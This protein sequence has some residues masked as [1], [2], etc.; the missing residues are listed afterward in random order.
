MVLNKRI[1]GSL[2]NNRSFYIVSAVLTIIAAAFMISALSTGDTLIN[3]IDDFY[4]EYAVED[5]EFSVYNDFGEEDIASMENEFD[6]SI[7]LNRYKD[8]EYNDAKIRVFAATSKVNKYEVTKGDDVSGKNDVLLTQKFSEESDISV[9]D[10]ISFGGTEH[11][12]TG[13]AI[14]SD[15]VYML[16]KLSDTYKNDKE[17]GLA[18]VTDEAFSELEGDEV[19]YYGVR[20][21]KDNENEFR[22]TLNTDYVISSY[23]KKSSNKRISL[24]ES[25]GKSVS[26]MAATLCPVLFAIVAMIVALSLGRMVKRESNILGTFMA[27]GYKKSYLIAFYAKLAVI[28]AIAG[29]IIGI[30]LGALLIKPF[31]VFYIETDFEPFSYS[32]SY[33]VSAIIIAL[34]VPALL[35]AATAAVTA[36]VM[37]KKPAIELI[38]N[39]HKD[40]RNIKVMVKSE[41]RVPFKMQVRSLISHPLRSLVTIV[42]VMVATAVLTIGANSYDA[43]DYMLKKGAEDST[44][45]DYQYVLNYLGTEKPDSGEGVL[46]NTYEVEDADIDL[47]IA[48]ISEDSEYFGSETVDGDKLDLDKYYLTYAASKTFGAEKGEKL[49]FYD[50]NTLKEREVEIAGIIDDDM[51]AYMYTGYKNAADIMGVDEGTYNIIVSDKELDIPNDKV[52]QVITKESVKDQLESIMSMLM[53]GIYAIALVG[54]ILSILILYLVMNM[55]IT[56]SRSTISLLKILGFDQKS[57]SRMTI[58]S[59]AIL[60]VIGFVAGIPLGRFYSAASFRDSMGTYGM[61]FSVHSSALTLILEVLIIFAAYFISLR[62]LRKKAYGVDMVEALKDFRKE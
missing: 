61:T 32:N 17:F 44:A 55:T 41:A 43:V 49:S 3:A 15:Y 16:E 56:E 26:D 1:K 4:D 34:V 29:S 31:A 45:F 23:M 57:V 20:Y 36:Y 60:T 37:L 28:P 59:N 14:K 47:T 5:A 19:S 51:N 8:I 62:R 2:K 33:S 50:V 7:E 10:S 42:G 38:N 58:D 13:Y 53:V 54:F 52:S 21:N 11:T 25:Q 18:I 35:Y 39:S 40:N 30:I 48:G 22:K 12:V 6:L 9:G 27:M 24:P 46:M